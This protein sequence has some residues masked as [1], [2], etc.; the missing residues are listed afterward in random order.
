MTDASAEEQGV[1]AERLRFGTG[2]AESERQ[3]IIERLA[4]LGKRLLSYPGDAVELRLSVKDRD[5][6]QQRV[7]LECVLPGTEPQVAH[8]YEQ[9]LPA[10]LAEVRDELIHRLDRLKTRRD[11]RRDHPHRP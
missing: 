6:P 11:P 5:T 4:G 10:A 1:V 3:G 7:T 8:S 9:D 2:L